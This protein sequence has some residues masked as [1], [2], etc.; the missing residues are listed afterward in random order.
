MIIYR[1]GRLLSHLGYNPT[2]QGG[3]GGRGV[4]LC[5][6]SS[7]AIKLRFATCGGNGPT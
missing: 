7:N 6:K 1:K 4:S 2:L 5:K 3:K